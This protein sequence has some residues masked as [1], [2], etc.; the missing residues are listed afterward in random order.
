MASHTEF[1]TAT[2][3]YALLS[4]FSEELASE[5]CDL[6][7]PHDQD[8]SNAQAIVSSLPP[9]FIPTLISNSFPKTT[10]KSIIQNS[11]TFEKP[12]FSP[13]SQIF[14]DRIKR[15]FLVCRI[16]GHTRTVHE[17]CI[18]P[19]NTLIITG[20]D[21]S[22]IKIWHVASLSLIITL[23]GHED[24]K[25]VIGLAMSPDR[26]LL[27]SWSDDTFVR[28]WS[29]IDGACVAVIPC[30]NYDQP[31]SMIRD[32][33][34]SPCN[35]FLAIAVDLNVRVLRITDLVPSLAGVLRDLTIG[36]DNPLFS[37]EHE[38]FNSYDPNSFLHSPPK[39]HKNVPLK[40]N[41]VT[42]SFSPGGNLMACGLDS[43]VVSVISMSSARRWTIQAHDGN[44][45][46]GIKFIKGDFHQMVTWSQKGGEAKLW[47]F[48]DKSRE[49]ATFS[50]RKVAR[51][52]H[53][54]TVAISCDASL[55]F[56][57]T[58]TSVYAWKLR[59]VKS[60]ID[61]IKKP[62]LHVDDSV[63]MMQVSD[64]QAHPFL[65][66]VFLAVTKAVSAP[67]TIWDVNSPEK[68]IH[69]LMTP[70]EMNKVQTARWG[71][72]G[73]SVVASDTQGGVFLFKVA[74]G[75][76]C[77]TMPQFFPTDF[78]ASEWVPSMGQVEE[79]T[80]TPTHLSS[81]KRL[82]DVDNTCIYEDY[83][84]Y[85]LKELEVTPVF[86]PA[87]KYSWLSEEMWMRKG[88]GEG[89]FEP[90]HVPVVEVPRQF[91]PELSTESSETPEPDDSDSDAKVPES[92]DTL[93]G[94]DDE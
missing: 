21:D 61:K 18:D 46:D 55:I 63:L 82:L 39:I 30:C 68:P 19:A 10:F 76:I 8:R 22:L 11:R 60:Q 43:G 6:A 78:T 5:F 31:E 47:R 70:V 29:L 13:S 93:S 36:K 35:R 26:R 83:S 71:A 94:V 40:A 62:I 25:R 80:R 64:V 44:P 73:V 32:V 58:S 79:R 90:K 37:S 27:A 48:L 15:L 38:L 65:P 56:A 17:I 42:V 23:K 81:R 2:L 91:T 41:I 45:V 14:Y 54:V 69:T 77:R 20:S 34:F 59:A 51:R 88:G 75:P 28:L 85:S 67:I 4:E 89:R 33:S 1:E 16:V 52:A 57:C 50:V 72:D 7:F 74:E 49:L 92:S 84:P 87:T 86:D 66:S 24:G 53:L 12:D 9:D 3:C